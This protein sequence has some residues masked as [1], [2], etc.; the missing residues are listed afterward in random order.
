MDLPRKPER[1]DIAGALERR[2]P[3]AAIR[4]LV[5]SGRISGVSVHDAVELGCER[6]FHLFGMTL[7]A[8]N[9]TDI[10]AVYLELARDTAI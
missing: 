3:K 2:A 6:A 9:S 1:G 4:G 5:R 7:P 10:R 8:R